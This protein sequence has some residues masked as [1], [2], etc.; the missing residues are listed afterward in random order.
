MSLGFLWEYLNLQYWF[1][2]TVMDN[3]NIAIYNVFTY[4]CH[5]TNYSIFIK[6]ALV[7]WVVRWWVPMS[8]YDSFSVMHT[9]GKAVGPLQEYCTNM[10]YHT[11]HDVFNWV[12]I[13]HTQ[14]VLR[15]NQC[16]ENE[17]QSISWRNTKTDKVVYKS[18][19]ELSEQEIRNVSTN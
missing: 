2:A 13:C 1:K 17:M 19:L 4:I 14:T 15:R 18:G 16:W 3:T 6:M 9:I 11:M 8:Q 10:Q 12:F 5:N 7:R